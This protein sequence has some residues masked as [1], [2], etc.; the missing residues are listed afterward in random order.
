MPIR[1]QLTTQSV[2]V[3][4][5]SNFDLTAYAI[6]LARSYIRSGVEVTLE[7]LLDDIRRN[8]HRLD[9]EEDDENE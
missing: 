7:Q 3:L 8:P 2:K 6:K 9:E 4:F 5:K 1:D